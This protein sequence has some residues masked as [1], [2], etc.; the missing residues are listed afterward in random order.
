MFSSVLEKNTVLLQNVA[1]DFF[2]LNAFL[3]L[4]RNL[5]FAKTAAEVNLSPSALSR[6]ITRL[7][8]ECGA[9]FFERSNREVV[10]TEEGVRFADFARKC[11]E[12]NKSLLDDFSKNSDEAK[13][14]LNVFA[15]VTACYSIMPPFIKLLSKKF[16]LIQLNVETG[17]P[18]LAAASVREGRA[19]LAVA[20]ITGDNSLFFE[21]TNFSK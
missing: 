21:T 12:E 4:S 19:E 18:A 11:I 6:L 17:D 16:P 20:A 10:L 8:G 13:G 14:T 3:T 2:E 5:H 7:E 15:S 1:M 9:V